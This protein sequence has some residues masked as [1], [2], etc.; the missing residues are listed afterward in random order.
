VEGHEELWA[1]NSRAEEAIRILD[2]IKVDREGGV[3]VGG[4]NDHRG[5]VAAAAPGKGGKVTVAAREV[6][7]RERK[8]AMEEIGAGSHGTKEQVE[9][10]LK[11]LRGN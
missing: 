4:G 5:K 8:R 3:G 10:F 7:E 9:S 11:K 2:R 6:D 1:W